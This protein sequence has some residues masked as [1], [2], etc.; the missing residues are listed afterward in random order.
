M[1]AGLVAFI[2][3][4]IPTLNEAERIAAV[5][6]AIRNTSVDEVLVIDGGSEDGTREIAESLGCRVILSPVK[7][8]A[9]QLNLGAK[10]SQGDVLLFLH[11]DT[12]V[13]P[14]AIDALREVMDSRA[15]VVGGGFT[16]K[17]NSPSLFLRVSCF[18]AGLRS[19]L[20]RLFL[21]DQAMFV[22]KEPFMKLG[23]FDEEIEMGEDLDFSVRMRLAGKTATLSPA[24]L[25]S[26]RR[27]EKRGPIVQTWLDGCAAVKII[28]HGKE[29]LSK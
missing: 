24:V 21:G 28:K 18:I 20:F 5:I 22:R 13:T 7:S 12:T 10:E 8:R 3:A 1:F 19:R 11:A 23:T 27:F 14:T 9:H 26:A 6:T 25:S 15:E 16:R 4:I 2:S 17:F 29:K